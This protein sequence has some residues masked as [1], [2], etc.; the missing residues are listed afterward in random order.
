MKSLKELLNNQ[1]SLTEGWAQKAASGGSSSNDDATKNLS[2]AAKKAIE[3]A[4][5]NVGDAWD[6]VS[7][8]YTS[9]IAKIDAG[10]QKYK[11]TYADWQKL[12]GAGPE[13]IE[14]KIADFTMSVLQANKN[15]SKVVDG[16]IKDESDKG[17]DAMMD[18]GIFCVG[19]LAGTQAGFKPQD[20]TDALAAIVEETK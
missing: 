4:K 16:W 9:V 19:A 2:D 15:C 5:K 1:E 11:S 8:Q 14:G 3:A 10:A 13:V 12:L 7:K 20:F 17:T 6:S 18:F